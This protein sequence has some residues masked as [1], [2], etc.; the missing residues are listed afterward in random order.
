M[1]D[2][3]STLLWLVDILW[4][5]L[6]KFNNQSYKTNKH[7]RMDH[8]FFW[9]CVCKIMANCLNLSAS[10]CSKKILREVFCQNLK[11]YHIWS[12]WAISPYFGPSKNFFL[13]KL[14]HFIQLIKPNNYVENQK[15]PKSSYPGK[16]EKVIERS[17]WSRAF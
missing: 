13:K 4:G 9:T 12:F 17:D 3:W 7:T 2:I 16:S 14:F 5:N 8:P 11:T 1:L 10:W 6:F 15:N